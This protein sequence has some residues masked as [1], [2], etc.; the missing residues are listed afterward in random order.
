MQCV[1]DLLFVRKFPP[2]CVSD[3]NEQVIG[4]CSNG[5]VERASCTGSCCNSLM[6][7][8]I[9]YWSDEHAW[10]LSLQLSVGVYSFSKVYELKFYTVQIHEHKGLF[11]VEYILKICSN[12]LILLNGNSKLV[13]NLLYEDN[14]LGTLSGIYI[15]WTDLGNPKP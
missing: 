14:L 1:H 15:F 13:S 8:V 7:K 11:Q 9:Q 6:I 3:D 4:C 2:N 12:K 10:R 5:L